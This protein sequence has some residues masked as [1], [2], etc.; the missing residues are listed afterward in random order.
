[1]GVLVH[2]TIARTQNQQLILMVKR[3][4]IFMIK[5]KLKKMVFIAKNAIPTNIAS[6]TQHFF[7]CF[8]NELVVFIFG[9]FQKPYLNN[10]EMNLQFV[11]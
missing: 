8:F 11:F 4:T 7:W 2:K 9:G 1:M 5:L 3:A 10:I 6:F